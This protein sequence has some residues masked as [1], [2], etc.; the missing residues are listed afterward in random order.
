MTSCPMAITARVVAIVT[1]LFSAPSMACFDCRK[2][3]QA[4]VYNQDFFITL[5]MLML[6]LGILVLCGCLLNTLQQTSEN[7][8]NNG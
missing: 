8:I 2:Q 1:M 7:E 4:S 6:P 3:V 5:F